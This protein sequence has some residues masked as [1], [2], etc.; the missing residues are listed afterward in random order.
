M[1]K[2]QTLYSNLATEGSSYAAIVGQTMS[3]AD[4]CYNPMNIILFTVLAIVFILLVLFTQPGE[5][6]LVE[7]SLIH[8]CYHLTVEHDGGALEDDFIYGMVTNT[9]SVGGFKGF[10]P[11]QVSLDDGVFEVVL[12]RQPRKVGDLQDALLS[13]VR[14]NA[15]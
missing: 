3:V 11:S 10:P 1:Y 9:N 15:E 5:H 8:I 13:L 7:L 14:Q 12:V 2:I 4:T 6:E